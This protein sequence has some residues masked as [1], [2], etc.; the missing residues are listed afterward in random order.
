MITA[1]WYVQIYQN[2][3]DKMEAIKKISGEF[4][5][6]TVA[7]ITKIPNLDQFP[8]PIEE[9]RNVLRKQDNEWRK[10]AESTGAVISDGYEILL[11]RSKI[12]KLYSVLKR[13]VFQ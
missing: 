4:L 5:R 1:E 3:Q 8:P 13:G 11:Q 7:E 10:F 12:S 6:Q 9:M 2:S